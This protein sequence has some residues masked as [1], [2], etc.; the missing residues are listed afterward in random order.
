MITVTSDC[1]EEMM[2]IVGVLKHV[3]M[4]NG[5]LSVTMDGTIQKLG[6]SVVK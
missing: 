4:D 2:I 3:L 5:A 6:L 1:L